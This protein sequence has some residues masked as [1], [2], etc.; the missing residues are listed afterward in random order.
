MAGH[1]QSE[2]GEFERHAI[3]GEEKVSRTD[4]AMNEPRVVNDLQGRRRLTNQI[5]STA[6]ERVR[7]FSGRTEFMPEPR[8]Y[9]MTRYWAP[10]VVRPYS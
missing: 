2:I 1:G 8:R 5:H 4:V 9:S 10:S 7:L 3:V 6:F